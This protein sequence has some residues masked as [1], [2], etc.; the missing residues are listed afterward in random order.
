[1]VFEYNVSTLPLKF[2][3]VMIYCDKLP[4][5]V[6]TKEQCNFVRLCSSSLIL[7]MLAVDFL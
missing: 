1:M 2:S 4:I 5:T 3:N 7:G 6:C